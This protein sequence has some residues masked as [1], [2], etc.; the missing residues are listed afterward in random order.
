MASLITSPHVSV[1]SEG[2]RNHIGRRVDRRQ[3]ALIDEA[4]EPLSIP[5]SWRTA[6]GRS[7]VRPSRQ[8][9]VAR[10]PDLAATPQPATD[11][12]GFLRGISLP[13]KRFLSSCWSVGRS[14]LMRAAPPRRPPQRHRCR[15]SAANRNSGDRR[16]AVLPANSRDCVARHTRQPSKQRSRR[17]RRQSP[18]RHAPGVAPPE[19]L[20]IAANENRHAEPVDSVRMLANNEP[21]CPARN[22]E[23]VEPAVGDFAGCRACR[24][25]KNDP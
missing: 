20:G 5:Q 1:A 13:T 7:P 9:H 15:H 24:I 21:Q 25:P 6:P 23:R 11:R 10:Q 2:E 14:P 4:V 22:D 19:Q 3:A 12:M 17:A 16:R 18:S 8:S